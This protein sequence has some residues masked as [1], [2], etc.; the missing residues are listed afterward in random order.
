MG[1]GKSLNAISSLS[2]KEFEITFK[3]PNVNLL[4]R[5]EFLKKIKV[6]SRFGLVLQGYSGQLEGKAFMYYPETS[7]KQLVK[8]L[9]G[10]DIPVEEVERLESD[11]LIEIGNIFINS[12]IS[13]LANFLET[14]IQTEIPQIIFQDKLDHSLL[15]E[16]EYVIHLDAPF[17]IAH[18]DIE[19]VVGFILDNQ[20]TKALLKA[21]DI[22]MEEG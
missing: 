8:L 5:D 11:A 20:S 21:I 19:G 10:T 18:H 6:E 22:Y 9:L 14:E 12:S 1:M 15:K 7:G 4:Q 16:N 2:G 3:L 17:Q 13:C